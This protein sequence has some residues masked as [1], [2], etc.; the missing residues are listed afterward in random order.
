MKMVKLVLVFVLSSL[1]FCQH[2]KAQQVIV[3]KDTTTLRNAFTKGK[4]SGLVRNFL[5][6]NANKEQLTDTYGYAVA[7]VLGYQTAKWKNFQIGASGSVTYNIASSDFTQNDPTTNAQDRYV[8]GLYDV[9][10]FFQKN[11]LIR[12]EELFLRYSWKKS[13]ITFGKQLL[14]LPFINPQDG[15]IRPSFMEG[16]WVDLNPN[17][18]LHLDAGYL[19]RSAPRSTQKWYCIAESIGTYPTGINADGNRSGYANNLTSKGLFLI[20]G[21]YQFKNQTKITLRNYFLENIYNITF[22]QIEKSFQV[23]TKGKLL[24]ALQGL[25]QDAVNQGGNADVTKTYIQPNTHSWVISGR[26]AWQK[27]NT[28]ISLNYTRITADSRFL[29]PREWGLEPFFTFMKRERTDGFGDVHALNIYFTRQIPQK[30]LRFEGGI[31]HYQMPD[32]KNIR[33]NKYGMPSFFQINAEMRYNFRGFWEGLEI[34]LLAV[35]KTNDSEIYDN[36]RYRI[37]KVDMG[38]Y[39]MVL[40]YRS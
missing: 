28:Q 16:L 30:R 31:G 6:V 20:G 22:A 18:N 29:S 4:V 3:D 35:F 17:S 40:N 24:F 7:G 32:V 26:V 21:H 2:T 11:E 12:I 1:F 37:N 10:N 5:M 9:T 19:Y 8:I 27:K 39:N 25:R 23:A 15:R 36:E 13:M 38:N 33:L 34:Q 14:T